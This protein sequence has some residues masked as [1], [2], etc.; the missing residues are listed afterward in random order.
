MKARFA[1]NRNR[2]LTLV[3]VLVVISILAVLAVLVFPA[4]ARA[5]A[6]SIRIACINNLKQTGMAFNIWAG[7]NGD[8]FPMA[9]SKTNGDTREFTT[10][11]NAFRHLQVMSNEL[12]TPIVTGYPS[13][14]INGSI[15]WATNFT[16][17][18][19]SN[20]S[21][22]VGV[23]ANRTNRSTILGGDHNITNGTQI[24]DGILEL[25]KDHPTGWTAEMHIKV[26][27]VLLADSS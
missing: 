6:R 7:D 16:Y 10:G 14:R 20:I 5:K 19:N 24:Q 1:T 8:N 11:A 3:E 22:F 17:F 15:R 27:N 23:N 12:S 2:G 21:F 18:N 4:L 13:E 25:T 9:D 26:G